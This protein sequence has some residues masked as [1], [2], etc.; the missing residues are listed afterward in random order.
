[1]RLNILYIVFFISLNANAQ[2]ETYNKIKF[3]NEQYSAFAVK[4]DSNTIDQFK[5]LPNPNQL[6][7]FDFVSKQ[8]KVDSNIYLINSSVVSDFIKC[9]TEGLLIDDFSVKKS[10]N[11]Q[12]GNGN[13]YLK[14]NACLLINRHDANLTSTDATLV[15]TSIRLAIQ[16]GPMLIKQSLICS[17]FNPNSVNR[18]MR[19]GAGIYTTPTNQKYIVFAVSE[20]PVSFFELAEFF[21]YKFNCSNAL[22]LESAN[23]AIYFP[24]YNFQ[25]VQGKVICNYIG[26]K[27][28]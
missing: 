5:R 21:Y 24:S 14:P 2:V 6:P 1:M 28:N 19:S 23:C 4:L 17:S 13:F 16:S 15:D 26:F 11:D 18:N 25:S 20:T 12:N 7:Y 8:L 9:T 10:I 3:N 22:S 27:Y